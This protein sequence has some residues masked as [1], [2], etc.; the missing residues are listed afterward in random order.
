MIFWK[1]TC[2][3]EMMM[4][5][6][7]WNEFTLP[8]FCYR[9]TEM[10]H[11]ITCQP[12]CFSFTHSRPLDRVKRSSIFFWRWSWSISK[13]KERSLEHYASKRLTWCTTMAFW[14]GYK[15]QTW[16]NVQINIFWLNSM[17]SDLSDNQ[18]GLKR[19]RN[20]NY[21]FGQHPLL[22]TRTGV[23]DPGPMGPLIH[24]YDS[25]DAWEGW[26][27]SDLWKKI[28]KKMRQY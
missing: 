5:P 18:Y 19:C 3:I 22:M 21:I 9:H 25:S 23:S 1:R 8:S 14:A 24:W 4:N 12:I 16:K 2:K 6:E 28:R 13:Y 20:G 17:T 11:T 10:K 27:C 7:L 26:F 15:S